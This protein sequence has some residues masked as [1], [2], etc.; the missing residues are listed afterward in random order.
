MG[1]IMTFAYMLIMYLIIFTPFT[2]FSPF[3]TH[4]PFSY[5]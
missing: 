5:F 2:A 3:S 1:L 4:S